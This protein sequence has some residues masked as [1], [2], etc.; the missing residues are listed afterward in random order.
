M[1]KKSDFLFKKGASRFFLPWIC[2]LM[3]FMATLV[4]T[5]GL[6]AYNSL[7]LWQKSVAASLTVQIPTYDDEGNARNELVYKDIETALMLLRT[8][9]GVL[10]AIVLNEEQMQELMTPWLGTD[11]ALSELPLPKLIDV[12]VDT[13]HPP[14]LEQLQADL[15]EQV[16]GAVLDSHRIWLADLVKLARVLLTLISVVLILLFATITIAIVY[17]TNASLSIQEYELS[18]VHMLG[19]QDLYVTNRY[20]WHNFKSAFMGS[21]IGFIIALP[22]LLGIAVFLRSISGQVLQSSLQPMQWLY[23]FLIPF[24]VA[25]LAF[26]TTF[27]TVWKFLK[28]FL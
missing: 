17:I 4:T 8:T 22:I 13:T 21:F 14:L 25:C 10:G 7:Q 2:G 16:P 9:P 24:S 28:R 11:A 12:T 5:G 19:A 27:Q 3:V 18:L 1:S 26:V 23:L 20:A 6:T 15:A